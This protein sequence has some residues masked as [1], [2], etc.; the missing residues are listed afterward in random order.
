VS[1]RYDTIGRTYSATRRADPRIAA[2]INAAL[3]DAQTIVNV[4]AGTG[5]YEP[6]GCT[7]VAVDPSLTMLRQRRR[8][9]A[10]CVRAVAEALPFADRAFD[11]ALAVL[12]LH[13]W[14]DLGRGVAEL[15]RVSRRQ[16]VLTFEPSF[17][18]ELWLVRDYFPEALDLRTERQLPD[19]DKLRDSLGADTTVVAVPIP[20]DCVDG[21][22]GS[23]WNRPEAYLDPSVQDG[24]SSFAQLDPG[25]RAR[26]TARLRA[27]LANGAWDARYGELRA[28]SETDLGYR[29]LVSN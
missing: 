17:S 10:P 4:G 20:S 11:A 24:M 8:D 7:V 18:R 15:R 28:K 26:G 2:Q 12:T 19:C 23:Y 27:D 13:H 3:G 29:L 1:A 14:S 22:A 16:V 5:N 9:A 25:V 21:F 6:A